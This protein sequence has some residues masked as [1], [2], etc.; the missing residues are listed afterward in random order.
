MVGK[1]IEECE[2]LE[3]MVRLGFDTIIGK[4]VS[5]VKSPVE[6]YFNNSDNMSYR[7]IR[8]KNFENFHLFLY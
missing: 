7:K 5:E 8:Q 1:P 4:I 2:M 6:Y 3:V